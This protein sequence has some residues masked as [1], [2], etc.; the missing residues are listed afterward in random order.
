[1]KLDLGS[2]PRSHWVSE[3]PDWLHLDCDDYEGVIKWLCPERIPVGDESVDEVYIGQFLIELDKV[4][5]M[6][7]AREVDRVCKTGAIL[8][9]HCYGN[10]RSGV[11]VWKEFFDSL[12]C[13]GWTLIGEELVN[14]WK[15]EGLYTYL[16]KL[17]KRA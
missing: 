4:S 13:R 1:M 8:Q 10:E 17:V 9:V 6:E 12:E 15:E 3:G 7:L 11:E 16:V 5:Y 14:K 2:G